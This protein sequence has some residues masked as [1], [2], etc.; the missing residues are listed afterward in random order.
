MSKIGVVYTIKI[1]ASLRPEDYDDVLEEWELPNSVE[2]IIE[3]ERRLCEEENGYLH[4]TI[5][6]GEIAR[7]TV[8]KLQL[9]DSK[10][11]QPWA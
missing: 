1:I 4:D 5:T 9:R 8:E 10:L 3:A 2:G 7:F 6:D 11:R